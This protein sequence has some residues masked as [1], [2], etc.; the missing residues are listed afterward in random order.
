MKVKV[1]VLTLM[2]F[3][4]FSILPALAVD[5]GDMVRAGFFAPGPQMI[6]PLSEEVDLSGKA[7]LEFSWH[8]YSNDDFEFRL[9]KGYQMYAANLILKERISVSSIQ[10]SSDK[11]EDGQ[12]YT[13]AVKQVFR[14]GVKSDESFHSF[15]IIKK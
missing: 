5:V 2:I 9:F 8:K 1:S 7:F 6:S 10:V 14:N 12:V 4:C 11:F 15:K 13:W 3:S